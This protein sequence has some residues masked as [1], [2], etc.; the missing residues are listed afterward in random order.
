MKNIETLLSEISD[1][2][3]KMGLP[4]QGNYTNFL[5]EEKSPKLILEAAEYGIVKLVLKKVFPALL[6]YEDEA[7]EKVLAKNPV[8]VTING[9]AYKFY[10]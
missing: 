8:D 10:C 4:I 7:I 5:I 9:V 1:M 2:R 3:K 6:K